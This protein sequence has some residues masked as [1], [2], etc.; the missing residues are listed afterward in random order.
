VL[1]EAGERPGDGPAAYDDARK[2]PAGSAIHP[3]C[4]DYVF[5]PAGRRCGISNPARGGRT[6]A[7]LTPVRHFFFFLSLYARATFF[8]LPKLATQAMAFL[9]VMSSA[10]MIYKGLQV[11]GRTESPI[12]VVLRCG[13]GTEPGEG[14]AM[15]PAFHRGDLLFL[16]LPRAPVEVGDICVFKIKDRGVPIVHRVIKAH[17]E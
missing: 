7:H 2:F 1:A 16:S 13:K 17:N 4:R 10:L 12:I 9:M 15:E 5:P 14:R 8:S 11:W 3:A 6:V